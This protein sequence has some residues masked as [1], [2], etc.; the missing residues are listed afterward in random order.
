VFIP[1]KRFKGKRKAG[2]RE[3]R[4]VGHGPP[5]LSLPK[6]WAGPGRVQRTETF[7][8]TI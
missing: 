6:G 3:A 5:V 2:W 4:K 7:E 1:A 8:Y